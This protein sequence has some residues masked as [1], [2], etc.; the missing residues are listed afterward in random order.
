M[1]LIRNDGTV[2]YAEYSNFKVMSEPVNS[3][4]TLVRTLA[5]L[6]TACFIPE[7]RNS[8][9]MTRIM[10][11]KASIAR[12]GGE[13]ERWM[14]MCYKAHLNNEF[15][16]STMDNPATVMPRRMSWI[17]WNGQFGNIKFSEMKLRRS[18]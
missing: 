13:V 12:R 7:M 1:D 11:Q 3:S 8:Q 18:S 16:N 17:D 2:G 14:Y 4:W 15:Y 5:M 6:V 10:M 9:H